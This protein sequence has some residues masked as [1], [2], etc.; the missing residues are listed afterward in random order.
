MMPWSSNLK[1][2]IITLMVRDHVG[3]DGLAEMALRETMGNYYV[4]FLS[5]GSLSV[6]I[7]KMC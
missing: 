6:Q 3:L 2:T 4:D 7:C 5:A 1:P